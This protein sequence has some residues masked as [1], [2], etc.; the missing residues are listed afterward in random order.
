MMPAIPEGQLTFTFPDNWHAS[1][2]DEWTFYR[3]QFIRACDVPCSHCESRLK[4]A[5]C[6][7]QQSEGTKGVDILAIEPAKICWQ[8]E[9]KDYRTRPLADFSFLAD[10]V[11]LKVK[12]TLAALVVARLAATVPFEKQQAKLALACTR[13]RVVLH[14]EQPA[15]RSRIHPSAT[16]QVNVLQR[17][18]QLVKSIDPNP[19]VVDKGGSTGVGV[20]WTVN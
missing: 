7:R 20:G 9:I 18:R 17:L 3:T 19:L 1:K 12:D 13:F 15:T 16:R 11:A 4:C 6:G 10:A 2:F 8:I 5:E 14:L